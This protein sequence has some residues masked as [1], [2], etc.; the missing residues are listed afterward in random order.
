MSDQV[1]R[2]HHGNLYVVYVV[3][4]VIHP[5]CTVSICKYLHGKYYLALAVC[6]VL[7][8]SHGNPV[9]SFLKKGKNNEVNSLRFKEDTM[10]S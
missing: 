10:S 1:D 9:L 4:T 5:V 8:Y 7:K 2:S 3:C 6:A